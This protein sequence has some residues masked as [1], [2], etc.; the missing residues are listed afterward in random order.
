MLRIIRLE[1]RSAVIIGGSM[2]FILALIIGI[3]GIMIIYPAYALMDNPYV[4]N[5]T[6]K[7][8]I[9]DSLLFL[10]AGVI[11]G[12]IAGAITGLVYNFVAKFQGGLRVQVVF[13]D[14]KIKRTE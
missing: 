4:A 9:S 8:L 14:E 2:G 7:E 3:L 10:M 6:F 12:A 11:A 5:W 1:L 13:E